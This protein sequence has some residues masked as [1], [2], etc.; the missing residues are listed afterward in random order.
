MQLHNLSAV[1]SCI[2]PWAF[3]QGSS[4]P[5]ELGTL[6][7]VGNVTGHTWSI[8][9]NQNSHIIVSSPGAAACGR[10]LFLSSLIKDGRIDYIP[11]FTAIF[12]FSTF[13]VHFTEMMITGAYMK[14]KAMT[15]RRYFS[16]NG[17]TLDFCGNC[18]G[19]EYS[20]F[21]RGIKTKAGNEFLTRAGLRSRYP[22]ELLSSFLMCVRQKMQVRLEGEWQDTHIKKL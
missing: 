5:S 6:S 21:Q 15:K 16:A 19:P 9:R 22:R 14:Q 1:S 12:S 17:C 2:I 11:M 13:L 10:H 7:I 3:Y 20:A 8:F 4:L 18:H